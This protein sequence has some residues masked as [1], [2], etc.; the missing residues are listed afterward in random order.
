MSNN[1]FKGVIFPPLHD[2]IAFN[3]A[4]ALGSPSKTESSKS[5]GVHLS[6]TKR[7][8]KSPKFPPKI[9]L[10]FKVDF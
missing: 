4:N 5:R 1:V 3:S 7:G 10:S 6:D 9:G 2:I 8:P